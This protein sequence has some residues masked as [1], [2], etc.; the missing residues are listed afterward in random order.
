MSPRRHKKQKSDDAGDQGDDEYIQQHLLDEDGASELLQACERADVMMSGSVEDG[1]EEG[2]EKAVDVDLLVGLDGQ[3]WRVATGVQASLLERFAR[4]SY[5]GFGSVDLE[6]GGVAVIEVDG[7]QPGAQ[8]ALHI[9]SPY[10]E[11]SER[12]HSKRL[13]S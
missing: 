11:E 12:G 8:H 7:F 1:T 9:V 2:F 4:Q 5:R 10:A 13:I 3:L 6:C